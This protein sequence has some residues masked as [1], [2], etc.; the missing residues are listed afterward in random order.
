M[1]ICLQVLSHP[2][3]AI[4]VTIIIQGV[5]TVPCKSNVLICGYIVG[6]HFYLLTKERFVMH[7]T[8][9]TAIHQNFINSVSFTII[10]LLI[11]LN[12]WQAS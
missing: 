8:K 6:V 7:H 5:T 11:I 3:N 2:T 10:M 1:Q 4:H 9:L 12:L